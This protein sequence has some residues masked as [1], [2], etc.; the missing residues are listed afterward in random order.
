MLRHVRSAMLRLGIAAAAVGPPM[1]VA[2]AV[3][4]VMRGY[5]GEDFFEDC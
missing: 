3:E 1:Q 5:P 2:T 4:L